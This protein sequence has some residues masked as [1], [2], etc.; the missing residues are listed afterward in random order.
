MDIK[1]L[2]GNVRFYVLTSSIILSILLY[3]FIKDIYELI[4]IYALLAVI[5]LYFT[6][7]ATPL[8]RT[9]TFLP[10]RGHYVKARRALGVSAFYFA[11]LH[12]NLA[13]FNTIGGF[14]GFLS[15]SGTT[16]LAVLAGE[17]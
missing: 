15:L 2:P 8:T 13:F 1:S 3:F 5:F 4:R 10:F 17:I 7:L 14:S 11:F 6:L 12:G 9:F 16:L